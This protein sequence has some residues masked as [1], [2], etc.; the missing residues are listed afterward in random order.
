MAVTVTELRTI[1]DDADDAGAWNTGSE[2]TI[3]FAEA[4]GSISL[5]V[6]IGT[7][8]VYW[9]GAAINF[10]TLG[11]ECIYIWT[12]NTAT[13][14]SY[15]DGA[16]S[17]HA[18]WLADGGGAE[19]VLM[20]AGNDRLVFRH[21]ETQ[22]TFMCFLIDVDYLSAKNDLGEIHM[23]TDLFGD[24]DP[25]D[26]VQVGVYF[27]TT[28]KALA[29]GF[30]CFVDIIRY[31]G[32][33]DGINIIGG[34]VATEGTF[35]EIAAEDRATG[36]DKAH[37]I[38][39]EYTANT[40]GVQGPMRFGDLAG[41][42]STYF[43]DANQVVVFEDRDVADDKF[44]IFVEA[45]ATGTNEF[46]LTNTS[47]S[48]ARPGVTVDMSSS[49]I[50]SLQID[51][52]QFT[53]LRRAIKFP[54]D[55]NGTTRDHNVINSA[56]N[57]CDQIDPGTAVFTG[58]SIANYDESIA[59]DTETE[60]GAVLLDADGTDDWADLSFLSLGNGH[61]IYITAAGSYTFTN[62]TYSG[63]AGSDGSTGDEVVFNDSGGEVI[64]AV[65]GGDSPTV[66]NGGGATT[67]VTNA[68]T[69]TVQG[70]TE[71]AAV[72]VL[73]NDTVGTLTLGDVIMEGLA[74]AN[75]EV[76]IT[77][78]NYEAAFG[79]ALDVLVRGRNQGIV[80]A[81]IA[82]DD[83]AFVDE[84]PENND[85]TD[86]T[87]TLLPVTPVVDEDRYLWGHPEQ[88]GKIKVHV[89]TAGTG[90]FGITWQY[91]ATG[92][93]WT[94]LS[95][96]V[97]GTSSFSVLGRNEISFTIPGDWIV[98]TINSQG[99]YFYIR[100]AY[101][102]GSVTITPLARKATV[103]VTRYLATG[104]QLRTITSDGMNTTVPWVVDT[105]STF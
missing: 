46:E 80:T 103:D 8:Q 81:G 23:V 89:T 40:Y 20:N 78:F 13:Q 39:R 21:S 72:T 7:D 65:S 48:S 34:G 70:V 32:Q 102:A 14:N 74:D 17:S 44:A 25:T 16:N 9:E 69:V 60:F 11:N 90:G 26:I 41:V 3:D 76:E 93:V 19:M 67:I 91:N 24:F 45:N 100:A 104:D 5:A 105:I 53:A 63:Y 4:I 31:G 83:G 18:I 88:F 96:V 58:N 86:D 84:T 52:C 71:G 49:E 6:N 95:D 12:A 97:D 36:E 85:N 79:A 2:N 61:A 73:A 77:D 28:S 99:P 54:T 64:I 10:T 87:V 27:V 38:I 68:V 35:A 82:D 50:N 94:N 33:A 30:N 22:V 101:T 75:G 98:R 62:F 42:T 37:G 59:S 29:G 55:T 43:H 15:N 1:L 57:D 51:S 47:I 66:R 92:D 56:F